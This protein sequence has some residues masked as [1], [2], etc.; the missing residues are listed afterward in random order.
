LLSELLPFDNDW[1]IDPDTPFLEVSAWMGAIAGNALLYAITGP[2]ICPN[3][4]FPEGT[5]VATA[6]GL[7]PIEE[8]EIGDWVWAWNPETGSLALKPVQELFRQTVS[9]LVI[10]KV[11]G[12]EIRATTEHPFWIDGRGWTPASEI[13]AGD[14]LLLITGDLTPVEAVA[15]AEGEF[16]VY[17]FEV[18]EYHTYFVSVLGVSVHNACV[19]AALRELVD[20]V[21]HRGRKALSV[22]D[23]ETVLKWADEINYPGVR[24]SFNDVTGKHWIGPHIHIPGAGRGGHVPVKPGVR[25]R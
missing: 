13:A 4:C 22:D 12:E 8:I 25:P 16:R 2:N 5:E 6:E 14:R 15:L 11:A 7:R 9:E 24:A 21:T 3:V 20:E 23:A 1:L 19:R 18:V 17:N 10:I